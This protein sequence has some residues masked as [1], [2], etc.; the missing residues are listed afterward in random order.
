MENNLSYAERIKLKYHILSKTEKK[1]ADYVLAVGFK[2]SEMTLAELAQAIVVSE[3]SIVRFTKALNFKGFSDFKAQVL[4]DWGK[5]EQT[6]EKPEKFVDLNFSQEDT[7]D[8]IPNK[9]IQSTIKG[10]EDTLKIFD[11][12]AFNTAIE[13]ILVADRIEVFGLGTSGSIALDFVS[14]LIRIG[15]NANYFADNHLGQLSARSLKKTDVAIAITHSGST[16]DAVNTLEIAQ[17]TGAKTI[18]LTN[19]KATHISKFA[20]IELLTGDHETTFYSETMISRTSLL[21]LV[22][23]LYMG[24]LLSD[25]ERFTTELHQV[26][27]LVEGKNY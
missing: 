27:S 6:G 12:Q 24:I 2:V 11:Y 7:I 10:L 25:Y 18:A 17:K 3:P 14:K 26:N 13:A 21:S 9:I 4:K 8:S 15:L 22:D 16:I 1:I 5:E 23:M 19:Y 20:D